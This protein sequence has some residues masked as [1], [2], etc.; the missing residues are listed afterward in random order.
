M[1][2]FLRSVK[3]RK[4]NLKSEWVYVSLSV[5]GWNQ[6]FIFSLDQFFCFRGS[7]YVYAGLGYN[8]LVFRLVVFSFFGCSYRQEWV[9][10]EE[11]RVDESQACYRF[12]ERGSFVFRRDIIIL[13]MKNY[14]LFY[15]RF[16][17]FFFWFRR[18]VKDF[19]FLFKCFL[20][21]NLNFN[22]QN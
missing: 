12:E 14:F 21:L 18:V 19:F 8:F 20:Y 13:A 15:C 3:V 5:C 9:R 10:Y 6:G 11:I 2:L 1:A 22:V 4:S 7:D 16:Q 17:Q